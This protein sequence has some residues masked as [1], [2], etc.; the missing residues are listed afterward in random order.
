M[1]KRKLKA[2]VP[3][4]VVVHEPEALAGNVPPAELAS[5]SVSPIVTTASNVMQSDLVGH[6]KSMIAKFAESL[7]A[8]FSQIDR[9]FSQVNPSSASLTQASNVSCQGVDNH[10]LS[11]PSPVAMRSKH[12]PNRGPSVSY[13]DDLGSSLGGLA[14]ADLLATVQLLKASGRLP[15]SFVGT[16]VLHDCSA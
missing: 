3:P 9:R 1:A 6:L 11:A 12:T 4:S 5:P 2:P 15:D 8:I 16:V 7:E 14:F 13:S 10:S